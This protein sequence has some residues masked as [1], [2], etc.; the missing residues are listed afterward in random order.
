MEF[1]KMEKGSTD[2]QP[3][4]DRIDEFIAQNPTYALLKTLREIYNIRYSKSSV[5]AWQKI[6]TSQKASTVF[7]DRELIHPTQTLTVHCAKTIEATGLQN[8][9]CKISHDSLKHSILY[10]S[11]IYYSF[12]FSS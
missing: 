7:N 12:R 10:L 6:I 2:D 4:M 3:I 8:S 9:S 11:S 5:L 1:D